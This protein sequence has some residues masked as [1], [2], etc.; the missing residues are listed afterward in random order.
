MPSYIFVEILK[1]LVLEMDHMKT[2]SDYAMQ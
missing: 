2:L 1:C